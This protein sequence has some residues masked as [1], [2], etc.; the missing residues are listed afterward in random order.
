MTF[1]RRAVLRK[2]EAAQAAYRQAINP[3]GKRLTPRQ[4]WLEGGGFRWRYMRSIGKRTCGYCGYGWVHR[5]HCPLH[6]PLKMRFWNRVR[7]IE[8]RLYQIKKGKS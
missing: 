4:A 7:L 6:V 2:A 1:E 8:L 5:K 3:I